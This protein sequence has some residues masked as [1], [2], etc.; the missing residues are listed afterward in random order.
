MD[1][2]AISSQVERTK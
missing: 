2:E 1:A